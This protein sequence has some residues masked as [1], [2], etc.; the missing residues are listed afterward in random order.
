MDWIK[1]SLM[2]AYGTLVLVVSSSAGARPQARRRL[3]LDTEGA[4]AIWR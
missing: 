3:H 1:S 4:V 2:L